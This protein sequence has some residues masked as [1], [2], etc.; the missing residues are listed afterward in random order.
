MKMK[1]DIFQKVYFIIIELLLFFFKS[2]FQIF[3]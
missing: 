1:I 3:I 2:K